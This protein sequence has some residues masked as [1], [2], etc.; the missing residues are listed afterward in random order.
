MRGAESPTTICA[1][2]SCISEVKFVFFVAFFFISTHVRLLVDPLKIWINW[3]CIKRW[4]WKVWVWN[5]IYICNVC[6]HKIAHFANNV[7]ARSSIQLLFTHP[8]VSYQMCVCVCAK[9]E[10]RQ[11]VKWRLISKRECDGAHSLLEASQSKLQLTWKAACCHLTHFGAKPS[12]SP[13]N[14]KITRL[15][16]PLLD[17]S[18]KAAETSRGCRQPGTK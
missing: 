14:R 1:F 7:F 10:K 13:Q 5:I 2:F 12:R 15:I 4:K 8:W 6:C 9:R 17:W 3:I 16:F 18:E 11:R